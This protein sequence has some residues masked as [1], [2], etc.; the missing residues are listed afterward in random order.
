M[1]HH[2]I[3]RQVR[4]NG[5]LCGSR[6]ELVLLAPTAAVPP[7]FANVK[8]DSHRYQALMHEMQE[9][10]GSVYLKMR[11]IR[12]DQLSGGRHRQRVDEESWHLLVLNDQGRVRGCV[13]YREYS[14]QA[15]FSQLGVAKSALA[16]CSQ[17]GN[18]LRSSVEG[19]LFLSRQLGLS[20]IE[21]GGWAL[22]EDARMTTEALRMALIPYCLSQVLGG[23]IG[24]STATQQNGSASILRKIGGLPLTHAARE[25]P[26]YHDP[27]YNSQM[28]VLRFYS[29]A[30][31]PRYTGL[32]ADLKRQ[33]R[34]IPVV[35]GTGVA[36]VPKLGWPIPTVFSP[37]GRSSVVCP[38]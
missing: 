32:I 35:T 11:A 5:R 12:E 24:I 15:D 30:P 1:W 10:R 34:T 9:L 26:S 23:G 36:F 29:W 6:R 31:N 13:R 22:H 27:Q 28:E 14:N 33:L 18:H 16:K 17:W 7:H 8:P 19:E 4:R 25:L 2:L 21:V 38:S 3:A 37:G 20:Y